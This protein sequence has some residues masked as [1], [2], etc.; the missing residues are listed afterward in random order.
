MVEEGARCDPENLPDPDEYEGYVCQYVTTKKTA[1]PGR[2]SNAYKGE[3]ILSRSGNGIIAKLM[4]NVDPAQR[5]SHSGIMTKNHVEITHS[6]ACPDRFQ[7]DLYF[8]GAIPVTV[9][10]GVGVDIIDVPAPTDGI[11]PDVLKYCW[12]G[13]ITQRVSAAV[14]DDGG[15]NL[16]KSSGLIENTPSENILVDISATDPDGVSY[17]LDSF[18]PNYSGPDVDGDWEVVPPLVV[19]TDPFLLTDG[20][21]Q[22]LKDIAKFARD[23]KSH[24]RLF[25]YTD[26]TIAETKAPEEAGWAKD[27]FPSVCSSF[28]WFCMKKFGVRLEG[29]GQVTKD[30]DL[31]DI[32]DKDPGKA[33]VDGVVTRDGLYLYREEERRNAG[34]VVFD[35]VR[36]IV[37]KVIENKLSDIED[38][39]PI[40]ASSEVF[41]LLSDA[42]E[43]TANQVLN[44]FASDHSET[45]YKDSEQWKN[46]GMANAVSPDNILFWDSPEKQGLFGYF[47]P[48]VYLPAH[49][50][51]AEIWSW[52]KVDGD[53]DLTGIVTYMGE[54]IAG[55]RVE[56]ITDQAG[57]WNVSKNDGSF[58]INGIPTKKNGKF[59]IKA[60][61]ILK[62][63][64]TTFDDD[65]Y[66]SNKKDPDV[67]VMSPT[68]PGY[69]IHHNIE[70]VPPPE[71]NRLIR[72]QISGFTKETDPPWAGA[73][74]N[75]L[76]ILQDVRLYPFHKTESLPYTVPLGESDDLE[77]RMELN[78]SLTLRDDS[79]VEITYDT[80]LYE[81]SSYDTDDLDA[82]GGE[83]FIVSKNDANASFCHLE[84]TEV[85]ASDAAEVSIL[86]KNWHNNL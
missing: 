57:M 58:R 40:L 5:Y 21:I 7:S 55:V 31:E 20:I 35:A 75:Y 62:K 74:Y 3:I 12:P 44:T 6:T 48:L 33:E 25:C 47:E 56:V 17:D 36:D 1:I 70:V 77:G 43:D 86:A 49:K 50:G 63:D 60:Y 82:Q 76:D 4:Q 38:Y 79:S 84:S 69:A 9:V 67:V 68:G 28:I 81:G 85:G 78:I 22:K 53:A 23:Q 64:E 10:V 13:K 45:A 37:T 14:G 42:A 65:I 72:L 59:S 32:P 15:L 61:R 8:E 34:Q 24:Y 46:P 16:E 52:S 29:P 66:L 80:R 26:P 41:D 83:T 11:R 51:I 19:K 30:S 73:T 39:T 18:N 2:F 27:S 71:F 54:P